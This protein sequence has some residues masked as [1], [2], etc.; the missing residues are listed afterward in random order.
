MIIMLILNKYPLCIYKNIFFLLPY[1]GQ[2][3]DNVMP[4]VVNIIRTREIFT[5]RINKKLIVVLASP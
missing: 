1:C 2:S 4:I 5:T 3:I